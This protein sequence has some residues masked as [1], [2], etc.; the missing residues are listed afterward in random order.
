MATVLEKQLF[1]KDD[2][3][4]FKDDI[5]EEMYFIISGSVYILASNDETVV[6]TLDKTKK[7]FFGEV[8]IL[9]ENSK[10]MCS[11]VAQSVC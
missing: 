8:A 4:I 7:G 1:L 2:Y 11:V 3:I 9:A 5:G 10:R 6:A